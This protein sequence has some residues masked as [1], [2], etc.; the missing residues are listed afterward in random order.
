MEYTLKLTEQ[1]AQVVLNALV[2]EPYQVSAAVINSIQQ[3]A[4]KQIEEIN[5]KK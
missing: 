3:Q 4:T 1:E 2:K 5:K